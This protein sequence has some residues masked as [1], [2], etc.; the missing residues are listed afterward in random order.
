MKGVFGDNIRNA[1]KTLEGVKV[2]EKKEFPMCNHPELVPTMWEQKKPKPART[3][4]E[5][6]VHNYV[7]PV[8]G[9]GV[10]S[11]PSCNCPDM[12]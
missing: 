10:G 4:G 1:I 3:I 11:A 7:C 6:P 12:G 2:Q 9:F 5:C 8:C